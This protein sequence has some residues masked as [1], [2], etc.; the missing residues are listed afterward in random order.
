[1]CFDLLALDQQA[2]NAT[3]ARQF[4]VPCEDDASFCTRACGD[5]V[6]GPPLGIYSIIPNQAEPTRQPT[7][8]RIGKQQ[9]LL[10]SVAR[11]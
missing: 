3:P 4:P 1:L 7:E 6:I 11:A 9:G 2:V 5:P 10:C 8:H